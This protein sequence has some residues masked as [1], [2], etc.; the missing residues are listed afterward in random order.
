MRALVIGHAYVAEDNRRKWELL[1]RSETEIEIH[2]P[3]AWPSWESYYR[4]QPSVD[5]KL[6]IKT[7][8]ALRIGKEDQYFFF[9]KIFRGLKKGDFDVLHVEQGAAAMVYFQA[10]YE[11]NRSSRKTKTCFFTWINWESRLRGPWHFTETYNLRHSDGAIAGN[12]EAADILRR[13]GFRGKITVLP[14]LGVDVTYY[15]PLPNPELREEL[16][17]RGVVI[18]FVGRLVEEKGIRLLVDAVSQLKGDLSLLI[19][20]SGPLEKEISQFKK[21]LRV[22]LI[23]LPAVPHNKVRD[24]L[25]IMDVLVLPSYVIPQWKEQFGHVLIEAMACEVPVL[26]SNSAAIPEV[27][28][29]A[30]LLF[31]ERSVDALRQQLK[32]LVELPAERTRL[33]RFARRRVIE[34]YTHDEIARQTLEFWKVL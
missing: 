25:R 5:G 29:N 1:S 31:E 28:G 22:P 7:S 17:L 23:H 2:L 3:H 10:L 34:N 4:P 12:Q 15:S 19:V 27:I 18:G 8:H 9:P 14:Q 11:R 21:H 13:H 32:T 20:G 6:S 30:G 16:G 33:G 26:G 24:Y